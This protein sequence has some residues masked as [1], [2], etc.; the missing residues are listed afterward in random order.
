M[1]KEAFISALRGVTNGQ[2][3]DEDELLTEMVQVEMQNRVKQFEGMS[4]QEE[5]K[6]LRLTVEQKKMIR[7]QD[8]K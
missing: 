4:K 8:R 2:M 6:L 5:N 3:R 7:E 1:Q